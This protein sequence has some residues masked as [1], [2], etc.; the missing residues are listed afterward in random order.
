[1]MV[2]DDMTMHHAHG[3]SYDVVPDSELRMKVPVHSASSGPQLQA[4]FAAVELAD[5]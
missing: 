5:T 1:M 4:C 2:D 3:Q